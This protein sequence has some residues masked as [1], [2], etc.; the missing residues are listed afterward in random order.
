MSKRV[1]LP[2]PNQ[3]KELTFCPMVRD[4]TGKYGAGGNKKRTAGSDKGVYI[5]AGKDKG[6]VFSF[7]AA[8]LI[9][10][11]IIICLLA[12]GKQHQSSQARPTRRFLPRLERT[13]VQDC[14]VTYPCHLTQLCIFDLLCRKGAL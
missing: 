12:Q 5:P 11:P 7:D 2:S 10:I 3:E 4:L 14:C 6:V 9:I 8:I 13:K 1:A